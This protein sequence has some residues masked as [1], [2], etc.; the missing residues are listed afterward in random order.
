MERSQEVPA[1]IGGRAAEAVSYRRVS[2]GE[3]A[4]SGLGLEAQTMAMEAYAARC[5]LQIA[6]AFAD[7][8]VSGSAP[9][10]EREGLLRALNA[11]QAGDV[12]LVARLDRLSRGDV[13]E[14]AMLE[15][16][17]SRRGARIVSCQ[18]EGT[19]GEDS[20]TQLLTRRLLQLVSHYERGLISARTRAALAAK[21]ARGERVGAERYGRDNRERA[22]LLLIDECRA[23]GFSYRDTAAELNRKGYST[24]RGGLWRG[25]LVASLMLTIRGGR[26][27]RPARARAT[28][29]AALALT[30]APRRPSRTRTGVP[31]GSRASR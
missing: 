10:G 6:A 19:E 5:G 31:A 1:D 8:G 27:A 29:A 14:A 12:L 21:R 18:G 30:T 17:V 26:R 3:Q 22:I 20:P 24:R 25:Q 9:L 7:E 2:T 11:L 15:E 28:M 16:L 4:A 13:L 23:A